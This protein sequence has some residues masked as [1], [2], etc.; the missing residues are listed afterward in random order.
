MKIINPAI[1][2]NLA[3]FMQNESHHQQRM[4]SKELG[5]NITKD[6]TLIYDEIEKRLGATKKCR[7]GIR[8][9]KTDVKHKGDENVPIRDFEIKGVKVDE[10]GN[11]VITGCGLQGFCRNCSKM[12]RRARIDREKEEKQNKTPEEIYAMYEEKYKKNTKKCSRCEMDKTLNEFNISISMECGLH[13]TCRLCSYEYGSSVGDRWILYMPDHGDY[14][15]N[16]KQPHT[17]DD[18]I[19]PLSLGGSNGP[20]NHQ[21]LDARENIQKSNDIACFETLDKIHPEMLSVRFRK[22]LAESTDIPDL[23]RRLSRYVYEDMMERSRLSDKD[24]TELYRRYGETNNLKR[25]VGRAVKK[26][27]EYC[28]LRGLGGR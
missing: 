13:N 24:L 5:R 10:A 23:K 6:H 27:R 14:K 2:V 26:F 3:N 21:L 8:G 19:F 25:D 11:I 20:L 9:G 7:F 18:H 15:Y 4:V 12:Y 28:V 16:K 1:I 22:A 17:H